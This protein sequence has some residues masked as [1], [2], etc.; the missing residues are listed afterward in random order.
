MPGCEAALRGPR[1][2]S[3]GPLE[4]RSAASLLTLCRRLTSV[5]AVDPLPRKVPRGF[6]IEAQ[7]ERPC[8][9]RPESLVMRLRQPLLLLRPARS[10]RNKE[11]PSRSNA[12]FRASQF[13]QT[14][15]PARTRDNEHARHA[16]EAKKAAGRGAVA[17]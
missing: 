11:Y 5:R 17:V 2:P 4:T 3:R 1:V 15:N 12:C 8:G 16:K 9:K 6:G 13:L 10:C 14:G 7:P